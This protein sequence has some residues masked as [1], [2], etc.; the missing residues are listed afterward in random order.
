MNFTAK[1]QDLWRRH[2]GLLAFGI[3]ALLGLVAFANSL[4]NSFHFDDMDAIVRNPALRNLENIPAF[5]VDI[6]TSG[7]G[8]KDW[9]PFLQITYALDYAV[10]GVDPAIFRITNLAFHIGAAWLL[11]LIVGEIAEIRRHQDDNKAFLSA[12]A[13]GFVAAAIFVVHTVNSEAVDYI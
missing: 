9:R 2:P 1:V 8:A 4:Y 5:F 6:G 3:L 7:P 11:F 13:I 12:P 10:G